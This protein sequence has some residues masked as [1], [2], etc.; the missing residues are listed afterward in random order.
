M[1]TK[2]AQNGQAFAKVEPSLSVAESVAAS[3]TQKV[4]R[5]GVM[6]AQCLTL[7][8]ARTASLGTDLLTPLHQCHV[9]WKDAILALGFEMQSRLPRER[10]DESSNHRSEKSQKRPVVVV[11]PALPGLAETRLMGKGAQ[12]MNV[13]EK[14]IDKQI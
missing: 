12:R 5:C 11:L 7:Q 2:S 14:V 4:A 8:I 1:K 3:D 10:G 6:H 9:V 13:R